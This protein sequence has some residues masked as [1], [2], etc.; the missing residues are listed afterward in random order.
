MTLWDPVLHLVGQPS[1]PARSAVHFVLSEQFI[2][3][4]VNYSNRKTSF[5]LYHSLSLTSGLSFIIRNFPCSFEFT[6]GPCP[7]I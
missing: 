4:S 2:E 7:P 5:P 1:G 6:K 3:I